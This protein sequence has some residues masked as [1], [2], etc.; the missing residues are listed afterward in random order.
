[1]HH[2][3]ATYLCK[4]SGHKRYVNQYNLFIAYFA[5]ISRSTKHIIRVFRQSSPI[6]FRRELFIYIMLIAERS[7][8][9]V[10]RRWFYCYYSGPQL[11]EVHAHFPPMPL[12]FLLLCRV[13]NLLMYQSR[14]AQRWILALPPATWGGRPSLA[15]CWVRHW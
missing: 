12:Y 2:T 1:M 3:F 8:N 5:N 10:S 7:S 9:R 4:N 15:Q 11:V 13:V 6:L 14:A